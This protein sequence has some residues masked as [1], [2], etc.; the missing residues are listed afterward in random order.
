VGELCLKHSIIVISDE[1]YEHLSYVPFTRM[2]KISP[3]IFD[4]TLTL[5]SAGKTFYATGWRVGYLIGPEHLVEPV[6]TAHRGVMIASP[7]ASQE[8]VAIAYEQ[9]D[10]N[11]FWNETK[12]DMKAK[13]NSF[14]EIWEEL[15]SFGK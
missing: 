15:G 7:S 14:N 8:A 9:A 11:N 6:A 1:V 3:E 12:T 2:A 5:G 13:M 10:K 4:I